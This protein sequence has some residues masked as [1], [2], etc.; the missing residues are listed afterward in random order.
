MEA[1]QLKTDS[2]PRQHLKLVE[3]IGLEATIKLCEA[4]GGEPIYIPKIDALR[5]A[6]RDDMIRQE[7]RHASARKLAKKYGLTVRAIEKITE[8]ISNLD[9]QVC[10]FESD[11]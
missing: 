5:G 1:K 3:V 2:L 11:E 9:G 6:Q 10:L 7:I 4:Y 8:G